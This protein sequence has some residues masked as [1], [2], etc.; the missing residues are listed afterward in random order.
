MTNVKD[1]AAEASKYKWWHCI[2]L[3]PGYKTPGV[4]GWGDHPGWEERYLFPSPAQLRGESVLDI[5]TMEGF[6]AFQ[7]EKRGASRVVAIDRDPP[8][9]PDTREAFKF[10]AQTLGSKVIYRVRNVYELEPSDFGVFDVVLMYGVLYHLKFPMY[11]L[12]RAAS[13]CREILILETHV[14]LKDD[15]EWPMMVFYPRA[16]MSSD[17]TTWWGPNPTCVD[18]MVEHVGFAVEQR[19]LHGQSALGLAVPGLSNARYVVRCRR[20]APSPAP[21]SD[22]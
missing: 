12:Y 6:F 15:F 8:G 7:A 14:T 16:E 2:E 20:V 17:P 11:G 19:F 10:A 21:L 3:A 1:I 4:V 5:G 13:V 22:V 18:A 9:S